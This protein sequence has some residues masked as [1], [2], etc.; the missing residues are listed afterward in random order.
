[1]TIANS[2]AD[3]YYSGT[4][5]DES[6]DNKQNTD[7]TIADVEQVVRE[8]FDPDTWNVTEAM[9]S[10]HATLLLKNADGGTGLVITGPSG[11][12][13]STILKF[14]D[15]LDEMVYRSDDVTP[16]SFVSHD[17][18]K[19]EEQLQEID[20]LPRVA[21]K[22][23]LVKDMASWFSGDQEVVRS[24]MSIMT[25]LMD[26]DGY[27]RDSGSHGQRGY[28]GKEYLFNFIGA[29]TPLSASAWD[30]MGTVGNR[31]VF[32][33]KNGDV[34]T[35]TI[36][37]DLN[38]GSEYIPQVNRCRN[39]VH[40]FIEQLWSDQGGV[41]S[42]EF[43]GGF[44]DEVANVLELFTELVQYARSPIVDDSPEREVAR[45]IARQL[46]DIARGRAI[47]NGRTQVTMSDMQLTARVALSTMPSKRRSLIQALVD[48]AGDNQLGSAQVESILNVS[49]PT[50]TDRMEVIDTL[51]I[52]TKSESDGRG[53][54]ILTLN[55]R[56]SWPDSLDF[57]NF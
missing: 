16:A 28:E 42:I 15:G 36:I 31:L 33:E 14:L 25:D 54:T 8:N 30:A 26:G 41:G 37:G 38:G 7:T 21:K 50:A 27:T 35:A 44:S 2:M 6:M 57:P 18:S 34:D 39:I 4:T 22:T 3:N 56:F 1:M 53:K 5:N 49:R 32:H 12:G 11:S 55:D 10:A 52:G 46:F 23:L 24:R 45:R 43:E 40:Q 20:L 48:P 19:S 47:L 29:T 17:S 9:L 13:K 51:G